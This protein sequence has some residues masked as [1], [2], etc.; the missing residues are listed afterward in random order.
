MDS[1]P[2]LKGLA[3]G[4]FTAL[5]E[6]CSRHLSTTTVY[7]LMKPPGDKVV[8]HTC[9]DLLRTRGPGASHCCPENCPF[10]RHLENGVAPI[11]RRVG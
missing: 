4:V 11:V 3:L 6:Q 9:R 1:G 2:T 10:I 8:N 5:R 7:P